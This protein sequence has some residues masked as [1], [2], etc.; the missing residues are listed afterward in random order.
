MEAAQ[1]PGQFDIKYV[2][3][4]VK[5]NI[6]VFSDTPYNELRLSKSSAR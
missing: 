4:G 5:A 6:I 3:E 1:G 2:T